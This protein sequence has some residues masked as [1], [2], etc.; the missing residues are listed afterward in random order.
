MELNERIFLL[1]DK[2]GRTAKEL[3]QYLNVSQSSISAWKNEGSFPSSKYINR[4]SEFFDVSLNY[5]VNGEEQS[6]EN[7]PDFILSKEEKDIIEQ[8]R[9]LSYENKIILKGELY[10]LVK[11]SNP[12]Y[13]CENLMVAE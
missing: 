5:L 11:E 12:K 9:K 7:Y 13:E 4:I 1:L 8:W 3:A 2:K 10:K 6:F